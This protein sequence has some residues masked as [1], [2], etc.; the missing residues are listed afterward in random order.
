M[1]VNVL[2]MTVNSLS[3]YCT[4][5]YLFREYISRKVHNPS[6]HMNNINI[7]IFLLASRI[8]NG[9]KRGVFT[10]S[11]RPSLLTPL[12]DLFFY[13]FWWISVWL[14]GDKIHLR[15]QSNIKKNFLRFQDNITQNYFEVKKRG[16]IRAKF[17]WIWK[18]LWMCFFNHY[19]RAGKGIFKGR[20]AP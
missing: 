3:A 19:G 18:C 15:S 11:G 20:L 6:S 14:L 9:I 17:F 13:F 1:H 16:K 4:S 10:N 12:L 2:V 8:E 5:V 7:Y